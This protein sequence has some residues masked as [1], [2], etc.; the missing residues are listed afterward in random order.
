M[1]TARIQYLLGN[2]LRLEGNDGASHY[3]EVVR[4][5]DEI[6]KEPGAQDLLQRADLKALYD[7]AARWATSKI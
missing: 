2:S 5:L 6:K 4:I 1:E 7:D 3:R